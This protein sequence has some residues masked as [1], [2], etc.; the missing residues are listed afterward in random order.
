MGSQSKLL[1]RAVKSP[2]PRAAPGFDRIQRYWDAHVQHWSAKIL[3]GEYYVTRNVEAVSTVLGSCICACLR[4][5]ET[6]VGGMNHFMLPKDQ[7]TGSDSWNSGDGTPSTRYGVYAMESLI[8][9][10]LKLG[11]R[12]ERLEMKLFGGGQILPSM[13]DIGPR[14]IEFARGFAAL[15]KLD[16]VAED[17]GGTTPRYVIY[18]PATGRVLLKRLRPIES[19]EIAQSDVLYRQ[20]LVE[21]P[22]ATDDV[23]LFD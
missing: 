17:V 21:Q 3:P 19:S 12:R 13:S 7:S 11:A 2:R 5:V 9:E 14:N 6:G 20:R 10:T 8:N 1:D 15:E 16:V 4:D 22:A 23:E 18:F